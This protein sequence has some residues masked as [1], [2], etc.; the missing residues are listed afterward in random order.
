MIRFGCMVA[1]SSPPLLRSHCNES[2]IY[3]FSEME[4]HGLSPN[5]HIHVSVSDLYI[6]RSVHI[7]SCSRIGRPIMGIYKSLTDT[8]L[9]KLGLR[10]RYSFSGNICFEFSVLCLCSAV[11]KLSLFLSLPVCRR[12]SLQTVENTENEG[13]L[14]SNTNVWFP[15][16][17]SQE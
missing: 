9:W 1:P 15:F 10:P 6:S 7:F 17:Y 12:P 8:R 14:G 11:S 2:P 16:M 5:F 4:L 3:V 13:P